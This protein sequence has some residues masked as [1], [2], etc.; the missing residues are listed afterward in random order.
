MAGE[1]ERVAMTVRPRLPAKALFDALQRH[2]DSRQPAGSPTLSQTHA[3]EIMVYDL[4]DKY[5][6]PRNPA[7][8]GKRPPK[9][10]Q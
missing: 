9:G 8:G 3:F 5:G 7:H 2:Y 10:H 1:S 6:I 4:G